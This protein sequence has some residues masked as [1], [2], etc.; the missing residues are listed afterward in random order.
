MALSQPEDLPVIV[1]G[2]PLAPARLRGSDRQVAWGLR[3]RAD[4]LPEVHA[5]RDGSAGRLRVGHLSAEEAEGFTAIVEACDT[6]IAEQR[7]TWWID[8][9][10]H[11]THSLLH[12]RVQAARRAEVTG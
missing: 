1:V 5:I 12:E 9:R 7:A 8:R 3:I 4:I 11:S 6:L 2:Q 10:G